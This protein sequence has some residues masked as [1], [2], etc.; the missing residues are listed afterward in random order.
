MLVLEPESTTLLRITVS[1]RLLSTQRVRGATHRH[2]SGFEGLVVL[3]WSYPILLGEASLENPLFLG[4][5]C[6]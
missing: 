2:H 6:S 5:K 1:P 3:F 4:L